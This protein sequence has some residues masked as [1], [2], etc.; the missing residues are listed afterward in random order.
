MFVFKLQLCDHYAR[1]LEIVR[2]TVNYKRISSDCHNLQFAKA[3]RISLLHA[4]VEKVKMGDS[5]VEKPHRCQYC[6][7]TFKCKSQLEVHVL[8]HTGEKPYTCDVC[9]KSFTRTSH[10]QTHKLI[11]TGEKPHECELCKKRFVTKGELTRHMRTQ[12]GEKPPK[13]DI[14]HKS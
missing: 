4:L 8:T 14:C 13:C 1:L 3:N 9:D 10:L 12:T 5:A 7:K 11:H 2:N 6:M